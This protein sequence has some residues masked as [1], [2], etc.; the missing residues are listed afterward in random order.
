M[1][2]YLERTGSF[3]PPRYAEDY[4]LEN[5]YVENHNGDDCITALYERDCRIAVSAGTPRILSQRLL[6]SVD[7][8]LNCHPGLLPKY[9]GCTAVEWAVYNDDPIGNTVHLM[10]SGIDE[11]PILAAEPVPLERTDD[12]VRTRV[13]VYQAGFELLG[14]A[15]SDVLSKSID[16]SS[17][18][19][20][21]EGKSWKPIDCEKMSIVVRKLEEGT[22]RYQTKG[23]S[24]CA[25]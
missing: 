16:L 17:L 8:V 24:G 7:G 22:Y 6:D 2:I 3:L 1:E 9:R 12:Y 10:T 15:T 21:G 23:T 11:G 25:H 4:G 19:P 13:K 14:R 20:Q 5:I 18:P